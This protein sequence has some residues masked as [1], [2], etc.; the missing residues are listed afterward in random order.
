[1]N[2]LLLDLLGLGVILNG[3]PVPCNYEMSERKDLQTPIDSSGT[4]ID[5]GEL[6]T[7]LRSFS[8][9]FPKFPRVPGY[10]VIKRGFTK[11]GKGEV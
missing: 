8:P 5:G 4:G 7:T 1:M 9:S 6:V 10:L 3:V 11:L 2:A